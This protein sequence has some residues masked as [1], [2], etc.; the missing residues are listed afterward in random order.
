MVMII[1]PQGVK[2]AP[3]LDSRDPYDTSEILARDTLQP[4]D[5]HRPSVVIWRQELSVMLP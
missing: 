2:A 5:D 3:S 1:G 4:T